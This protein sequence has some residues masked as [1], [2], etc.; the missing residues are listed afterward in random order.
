MQGAALSAGSASA[1]SLSL[2]L[3]AAGAFWMVLSMQCSAG[4]GGWEAA[5]VPGSLL[6]ALLWVEGSGLVKPTLQPLH[7]CSISGNSAVLRPST[8]EGHTWQL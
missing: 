1:S 4:A 3:S 5:G 2:L 6:L 7:G 8:Q